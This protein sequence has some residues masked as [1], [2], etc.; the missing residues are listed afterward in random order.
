[1]TH[2]AARSIITLLIATAMLMNAAV[3]LAQGQPSAAPRGGP[4]PGGPPPG[5]QAMR[6]QGGG[7]PPGMRPPMPPGA[8]AD[9][10]REREPPPPPP[11]WQPPAELIARVKSSEPEFA[12]QLERL[13]SEDPERWIGELWHVSQEA[14]HAATLRERDEADRATRVETTGRLERKVRALVDSL[15][16]KQPSDTQASSLRDALGQLFD[17]REEMR[18]EE[19]TQLEKR[20]TDLKSGLSDRRARKAEIVDRRLKELLAQEDKLGW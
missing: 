8:E 12:A 1:M 5:G 2:H 16:G 10:M 18:R 6:P 20:I 17:Q 9:G 4:P 14:R 15:D 7:R 3:G 11:G 19:I 13:K